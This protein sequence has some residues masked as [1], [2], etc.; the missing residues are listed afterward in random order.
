MSSTP[1]QVYLH[2]ISGS[3]LELSL[4]GDALAEEASNFLVLPRDCAPAA[5]DDEQ[6]ASLAERLERLSSQERLHLIGF[7][8][9]AP[10]ALRLASILGEKI[11]KI[12]L[13]S[14]AAPLDL[15]DY[16]SAMAG[17][18][19]FRTA[20]SS[21][22]RFGALTFAQSAFARMA[23]TL[24]YK[25]LFATAQGDDVGIR[26]EHNFATVMRSILKQSLG[27]ELQV[28]RREVR[29]YVEDWSGLLAS[30]NSPVSI[31]H[32][33]ADNWSPPAMARDLADTLP[34]C[35]KLKIFKSASHYSALKYYL[36]N[37]VGEAAAFT[38]C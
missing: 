29:W 3:G 37:C 24:I 21:S 4:F 33:E 12:D 27:D 25:A 17:E 5:T 16:L 35:E 15:G 34:N 2:G 9:G 11:E 22:F 14:A 6:I 10:M 20:R 1:Q 36:E 19:V 13:I 8:M 26:D 23:P 38:P 31:Y 18:L 30:V 7:S 32:G 28:Y